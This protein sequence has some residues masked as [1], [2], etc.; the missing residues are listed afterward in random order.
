MVVATL[1]GLV[2]SM[3]ATGPTGLSVAG[4]STAEDGGFLWIIKIHI[5][6]SEGK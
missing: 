6:P 3:F 5:I 2:V 1:D 4:S